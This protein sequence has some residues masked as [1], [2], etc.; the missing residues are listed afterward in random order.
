MLHFLHTR[1]TV[2]GNEELIMANMGTEYIIID[3][4]EPMRRFLNDT[5]FFKHNK[6]CEGEV[7]AQD[8]LEE[9]LDMVLDRVVDCVSHEQMAYS[10][11]WDY[12]NQIRD[13]GFLTDEGQSSIALA[14]GVVELGE[15]LAQQFKELRAYDHN[16]QLNYYLSGRIAHADLILARI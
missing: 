16:K 11:L 10:R 9:Y 2:C 3:T 14:Q 8:Y 1:L 4:M 15:Q 6:T 7:I 12:A 13:E 5:A